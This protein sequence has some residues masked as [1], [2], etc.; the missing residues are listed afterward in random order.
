MA[1]KNRVRQNNFV[2]HVIRRSIAPVIVSPASRNAIHVCPRPNAPPFNGDPVRD[3][4][5]C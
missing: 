5:V 3:L 2:G 4:D 1:N